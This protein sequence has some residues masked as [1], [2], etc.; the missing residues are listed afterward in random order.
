MSKKSRLV[1]EKQFDD[2]IKQMKKLRKKV[3]EDLEKKDKDFKES[4]PTVDFR[5]E[6]K[7]R[8]KTIEKLNHA[9]EDS[10]KNIEK[11]QAEIVRLTKENKELSEKNA[12]LKEK[13]NK[14]KKDLEDA[15][16]DC[17]QYRDKYIV[18]KAKN[19]NLTE[20]VEN[21]Q[22]LNKSTSKESND[23][24]TV[25]FSEYD[26][27]L[28]KYQFLIVCLRVINHYLSDNDCVDEMES[29]EKLLHIITPHKRFETDYNE[30][31]NYFRKLRFNF[32]DVDS[33]VK[34]M[35]I[36]MNEGISKDDYDRVINMMD[37]DGFD[38]V[39]DY[40]EYIGKSFK[41]NNVVTD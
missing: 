13:Y 9:V 37:H 25:A 3:I 24:T 22:K 29:E 21:L 4:D 33:I 6:I 38:S 31:V 10:D 2:S 30:F 14:Q 32:E 41:P 1:I 19:D 17:Q 40:L 26:T 39:V 11:L 27:F 8:D 12:K 23:Q 5:K 15:L 28:A 16:T 20:D 34:I 7:D 35:L 36:S 18:E